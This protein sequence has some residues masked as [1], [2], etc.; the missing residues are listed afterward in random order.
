MLVHQKDQEKELG[1]DGRGS[2]QDCVPDVTAHQPALVQADT[3][4]VCDGTTQPHAPLQP[5]DGFIGDHSVASEKLVEAGGKQVEAN[6]EHAEAGG[7]QVE[8]G[9]EQVEANRERAE[10]GGRQVEAG[11]RQVEA[12][13]KQVEAGGKQV[14]AGGKQVETGGEEVEAGG[15]QLVAGVE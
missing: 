4:S 10:A 9:G 2:E 5:A 7:K 3:P 14:E 8:A 15:G 11:G 12:G 1:V 6:R 13:G